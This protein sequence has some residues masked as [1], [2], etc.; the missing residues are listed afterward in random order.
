MLLSTHISTHRVQALTLLK[1]ER[2][3]LHK[4]HADDAE[5]LHVPNVIH[6]GSASSAGVDWT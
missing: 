3:G 4:E 1:T 6:T 5:Y 2:T